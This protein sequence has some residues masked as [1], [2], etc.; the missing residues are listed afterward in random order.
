MGQ[1]Q[2]AQKNSNFVSPSEKTAKLG[3]KPSFGFK[4]ATGSKPALAPKPTP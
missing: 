3:S 4:M 1:N 2:S